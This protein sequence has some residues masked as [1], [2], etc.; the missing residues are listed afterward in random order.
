M[1][2]PLPVFP[3]FS[4]A[5]SDLA[6]VAWRVIG[7]GSPFGDDR[8]GWDVVRCLADRFGARAELE[9]LVL[10]RPGPGLLE[11]LA[12]AARVV[13]VDAMRSGAA[14]YTLVEIDPGRAGA[15]ESFT[16]SHGVGLAETLALGRALGQ[17]P[18]GLRLFGIEMGAGEQPVPRQKLHAIAEQLAERLGL[19]GRR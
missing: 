6:P 1:A 16:S 11:K 17:L 9:F 2:E 4:E 10:D 7:V 19:G 5:R 3:D 18:K 14:P 13:V 12:G 8:L 15:L